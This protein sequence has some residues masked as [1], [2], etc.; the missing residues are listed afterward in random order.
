MFRTANDALRWAYMV[1][2]TDTTKLSSVNMMASKRL[3][4]SVNEVVSGLSRMEAV[5]QAVN[6][7]N[8]VGDLD[9]VEAACLMVEYGH[10]YFG[11][12]VDYLAALLLTRNEWEDKRLKGVKLLVRNCFGYK[13]TSH[14]MVKSLKCNYNKLADYRNPVFE[15]LDKVSGSAYSNINA[16]LKS[17][18]IVRS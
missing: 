18:N 3:S 7:V 17:K 14:D 16:V 6:I 1:K 13:A 5:S 15:Y 12:D 4:C 10:N 8:N 2:E 9:K 11:E